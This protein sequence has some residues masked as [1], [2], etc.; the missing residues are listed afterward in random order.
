MSTRSILALQKGRRVRYCFLHWDGD[1]HG[2]TLK[3]M[4]DSEI[5]ELYNAMAPI[6]DGKYL[7]L[8]HLY[9][10]AYWEK[11]ID[12]ALSDWME[13]RAREAK[14]K[15]TEPNFDME[16]FDAIYTR[17]Q[18]TAYL[19]VIPTVP[20]G[21]KIELDPEEI[22]SYD[23]LATSPRSVRECL[24]GNREFDCCEYV[25]HYNLDTRVITYFTHNTEKAPWSPQTMQ[26]RRRFKAKDFASWF[27]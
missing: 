26:R 23:T 15:N 20:K 17:P 5:E 11:H 12:E 16:G 25:W 7:F 24:H 6:D 22:G 21:Q 2:Q 9:P 14:E 19:P 13:K 8:E 10:Q 4:L 27:K 18:S 3:D 1:K